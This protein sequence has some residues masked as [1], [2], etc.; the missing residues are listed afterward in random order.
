MC[1]YVQSPLSE[2]VTYLVHPTPKGSILVD[3]L[4][5]AGVNDAQLQRSGGSAAFFDFPYQ[6]SAAVDHTAWSA[7]VGGIPGHATKSWGLT[8]YTTSDAPAYP[9]LKYAERMHPSDVQV[10]FDKTA[11]PLN[12]E[13]YMDQVFSIGSATS[14]FAKSVEGQE[15]TREY[16]K[17]QVAGDG[18]GHMFGYSTCQWI[19]KCDESTQ[20]IGSS[21]S[22]NVTSTV[23]VHGFCFRSDTNSLECG[24]LTAIDNEYGEKPVTFDSS[25]PHGVRYPNKLVADAHPDGVPTSS[26]TL[27]FVPST[28]GE[29]PA[30]RCPAGSPAKTSGTYVSKRLLIAGCMNAT[31]AQ[32]DMLAEVHVPAYCAY[33]GDY[34]KGCMIPWA[35]NFD[36]TA[37]QSGKCTF[38]THGCTD[39]MAVNYNPDASVDYAG[40]KATCIKKKVGCTVKNT[41]GFGGVNNQNLNTPT[42]GQ[43][44]Y[45]GTGTHLLQHYD[46]TIRGTKEELSTTTKAW[47]FDI[48]ENYDPDAN[49]NGGCK[50]VIEGCMDSTAVNFE[51]EATK[52][53]NT[54]C[55]PPR[56][57]CMM[58]PESAASDS[59]K[60]TDINHDHDSYLVEDNIRANHYDTNRVVDFIANRNSVT[61]GLNTNY[62]ILNTVH[63]L[64]YCVIARYGCANREAANYHKLDTVNATCLPSVSGCLN[65]H[66]INV[67]CTNFDEKAPCEKV[68]DAKTGKQVMV[69]KHDPWTCRYTW[70]ELTSPPAPPL[71]YSAG[72]NVA[73]ATLD[74]NVTA[75]F[76]I[77]GDCSDFSPEY[78]T[79]LART[80]LRSLDI[81]IPDEMLKTFGSTVTC[82][83]ALLEV[84]FTPAANVDAFGLAAQMTEAIKRKFGDT[85]ASA[86]AAFASMGIN[87]VYVQRPITVETTTRW[88]ILAYGLTIGAIVGIIVGTLVGLILCAAGGYFYKKRSANKPVYPASTA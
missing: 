26:A 72:E 69:T 80:I 30:Y 57:G 2:P 10:A 29:G 6:D 49:V 38:N 44:R 34:H 13:V 19:G 75:K 78:L 66:A 71:Q 11:V 12:G 86:T 82:G 52:N 33:Q 60:N 1:M 40:E 84:Y 14:G 31:D 5:T 9:N 28:P 37:K 65:K 54:W 39:S 53:S 73:R 22:F 63:D 36:P 4:H 20:F 81:N 68:T 8:Q 74:L 21:C 59:Y 45:A 35:N 50:I 46:G 25:S 32:Y 42:I 77:M 18:G 88:S 43:I 87:D 70:N 62:S 7:S 16:A 15:F 41:A 24:R 83:S 17:R 3:K 76:I 51:P 61:D 58:P 27:K 67:G 56:T 47:Q 48:V 23:M 79:A 85:A 64:K 55:L